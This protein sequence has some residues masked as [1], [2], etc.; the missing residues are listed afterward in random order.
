MANTSGNVVESSSKK[1]LI[2]T[3]DEPEFR[4][5]IRQVAEGEGWHVIECENGRDL[6][7][8]LERISDPSLVVLDLMMPE[9]DGFESLAWIAEKGLSCPVCIVSGGSIDSFKSTIPVDATTTRPIRD[10][11]K[12]PIPIKKIKELLDFIDF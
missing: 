10:T 4:E 1:T 5:F 6:T 9:M 12:K 3:D 11:L 8:T 2:I 7:G